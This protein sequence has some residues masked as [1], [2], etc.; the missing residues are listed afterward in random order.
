VKVYLGAKNG[1]MVTFSAFIPQKKKTKH[2][3]RRGVVVSKP[4]SYSEGCGFGSL[5]AGW[6]LWQS[7]RRFVESLNAKLGR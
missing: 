5:T 4:T 3:R 7:F 6:I 1:T 2:A